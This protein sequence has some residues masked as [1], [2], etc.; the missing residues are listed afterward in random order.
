VRRENRFRA[1]VLVDGAPAAAHVA[2]SGRL[3]DLFEADRPI[4]L[5]P[6]PTGSERKTAYDLKL[7]AHDGV[8]VSVD[9]RLPNPLFAAALERGLAPFP[10]L[11]YRREV[12]HGASRI[13]FLLDTAAGAHWIETKSVTLVEEGVA[14]FPDAPTARGR[15]HLQSLIDLRAEGAAA[16]VVF[17]V[18]RPD[19]QALSPHPTADPAFIVGLQAAA[20]AGVDLRAFVCDVSLDGITLAGEIPVRLPAR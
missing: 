3:T 19:A 16:S 14:L 10:H 8:L 18:Q 2:N 9:A 12:T 5:S 15:R 4:W 20:A 13:D 1:T 17:V 11:S 7:V 6:A